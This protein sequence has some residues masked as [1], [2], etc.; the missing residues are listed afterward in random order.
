MRAT[1]SSS[2]GRAT[3]VGAAGPVAFAT[4]ATALCALAFGG[5]V[6]T[7]DLV[8]SWPA[9]GYLL[10]LGF[11]SQFAGYLLIQFSLPRLPAVLT[12]M[13]LLIQPVTTVGLAG[14]LLGE[15]PSSEQ[16]LGVAFVIGGIAIA[17]VPFQR[18]RALSSARAV[19]VRR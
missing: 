3:T 1:C 4:L 8:P 12:S 6:G 2:A 17:T 5:L 10:A 9:H 15:A 7:L 18:V 11:T 13:I 19:G 14:V 16:L